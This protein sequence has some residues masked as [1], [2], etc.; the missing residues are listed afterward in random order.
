MHAFAA[1]PLVFLGSL[2]DEDEEDEEGDEPSWFPFS[3]ALVAFTAF[4]AAA[5]AFFSMM[6]AI[7]SVF[8]SSA[9]IFLVSAAVRE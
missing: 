3:D 2:M 5:A 8:F 6:P 1:S 4:A 9:S 7:R